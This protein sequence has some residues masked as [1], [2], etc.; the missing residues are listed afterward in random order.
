MHK[1][2]INAWVSVELADK[3][4]KMAE[5]RG[6]SLSSL[7][8]SVL[9]A[10]AGIGFQNAKKGVD[11]AARA[12]LR[13]RLKINPAVTVKELRKELADNGIKR[14]KTWVTEERLSLRTDGR[15]AK[16]TEERLVWSKVPRYPES[17][18]KDLG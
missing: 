18:L 4:D 8:G 13:A 17:I 1:T 5:E 14:C 10:F 3:L 6:E 9:A 7:I 16:H 11:E 12:L 2:V 15:G